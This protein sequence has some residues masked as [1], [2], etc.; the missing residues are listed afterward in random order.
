[1]YHPDTQYLRQQGCD[2]PWVFFEAKRGPRARGLGNTDT[3]E[4]K[5]VSAN[6]R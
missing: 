1:M 4:N 5:Y 6:G 2:D 3:H